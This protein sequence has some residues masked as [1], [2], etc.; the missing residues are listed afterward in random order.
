MEH[1]PDRID[2]ITQLFIDEFGELPHHELNRKPTDHEWSIAQNIEHIIA[3]NRSYMIV[4]K[5]ARDGSLKRSWLSRFTWLAGL[6]GNFLFGAIQPDRKKKLK[7][8][9]IWNPS[10]S[11]IEKSV[12]ERFQAHQEEFKELIRSVEQF[13]DS[14][15]IIHSPISKHLVLPLGKTLDI[16]I[17]HEERHLNQAREAFQKLNP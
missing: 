7:T 10:Q 8:I 3:I 1:F 17:T 5:Q 13:L 9:K 6:L 12:L 14:D 11:E 16:L 2:T 15:T 4:I